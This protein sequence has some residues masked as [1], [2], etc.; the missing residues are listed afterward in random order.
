MERFFMERLKY[1]V[2]DSTIAELLGVQ[3]FTNKESAILELVKNAYDAQANNVSITFSDRSIVIIDDGIGMSKSTI[4]ENWMH[5]GKSDKG[6]SLSGTED[7]DG[8]VLAGSK[9]VG[10]F[11]LARLGA[12]VNVYSAKKG[13]IPVKWTTDWSESILDDLTNEENLPLG[14]RIEISALRDR[15]TEK[16]IKNLINYLSITCNDDRMQIKIYPNFGKG[17]SYIFKK[18]QIGKNFVTQIGLFYDAS[19]LKLYYTI[20]SD[21]FSNLAK[22]YC[23]SLDLQYFSNDVSI[24]EELAGNTEIDSSDG[25]LYSMLKE[26]GNFSA[27]L[28]FSLKTPTKQD[29]ERFC[30]NY[31][32]LPDRY[33]EGVVLYRNAFSIASFD[34]EKDWLG[35]NQ[36]SR[37]SPAAA[38]HPT[39]AWRV[40]ANQ[41]S[42]KVEIDKKE[43]YQLRDLANRQGLEENEY[44]KLFVKIITIGIAAFERYRQAIIRSIDK[45]NAPKPS[46]TTPMIDQILRGRNKEIHLTSN[47]TK[48][49]AQEISVVKAE[50]KSFQDEK[51]STEKKYRYDVRILNVLATTVLKASSIAHELKNDRNSVSV[52]YKYIVEA[53]KEY[54]F[55]EDLCSQEYTEYSYKNVP[56]L[57]SR[58]RAI[59]QKIVAFMD[60]M[61]DEIE[62]KNFSPR[63]LSINS[64]MENI[65]ANWM[66]DYASLLINLNVDESVYFE[67]SED[68]F[69][70]IFDN[71]ILNSWQQNK[72][73]SQI[74][75]S[76]SIHKIGGLLKIVYEDSGVGLPPKYINDPMR[77][78]EVHESSRENGHGIGM[79]IVHNTIRMTGG[80]VIS[81]DGHNGFHFNFEL[82]EKL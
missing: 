9:G 76:I 15:W 50:S 39:G 37:K 60:T 61:L 7:N 74:V 20:K 64:I 43:N 33:D 59:N 8:R 38:T 47:E 1:I 42:G 53:L 52:N 25:E 29:V 66:R 26:L 58:N 49:L 57:L 5:V 81:I 45:K 65:K 73:S 54:G 80:D 41:L 10:R 23:R 34:G 12:S 2:E 69:T 70:A 30:Y 67:T 62:K 14:T 19:E 27:E 72:A 22:N 40:R 24:L 44:F 21:E 4:C 79:W 35:L 3:N 77:I 56:Q 68:I 31:S 71:L 28:Y 36:R 78:L 82:G 46:P 17:V 55:W 75:I 6:Y 18:P 13:E 11:A 16:S 51:E 63:S 48:A 32:A